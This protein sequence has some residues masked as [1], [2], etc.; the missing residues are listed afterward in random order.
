MVVDTRQDD[1]L[2]GHP[3]WKSKC[4]NAPALPIDCTKTTA[5]YKS[6]LSVSNKF[7]FLIFDYGY[8]C[9]IMTERVRS[10]LQTA[11]MS[12]LRKVRGLSILDKV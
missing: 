7:L 1:E 4:S 12:F 11:K 3:Y 9:C 6:K 2:D 10:Q 8:K 5:V